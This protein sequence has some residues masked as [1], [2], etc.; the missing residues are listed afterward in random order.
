MH[1]RKNCKYTYVGSLSL[2]IPQMGTDSGGIGKFVRLFRDL[3][4]RLTD[5]SAQEFN[6]YLDDYFR[7]ERKK[8]LDVRAEL[9][10]VQSLMR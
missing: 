5:L 3:F 6:S 10:I 7:D 1:G 2:S 9:Q 4:T 8:H